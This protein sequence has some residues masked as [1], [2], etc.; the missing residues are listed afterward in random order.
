MGFKTSCTSYNF[1]DKK[2]KISIIPEIEYDSEKSKNITSDTISNIKKRGCVIIR[3]VFKKKIVDQWN[4][5]L[6]EYIDQNN[7][8]EDQKKKFKSRSIF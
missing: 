3:N 1:F 5:D 8:Y 7:Y 6:E 2:F 4:I